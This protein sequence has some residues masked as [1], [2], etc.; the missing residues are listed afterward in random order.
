MANRVA[1]EFPRSG[2]SRT[3]C[4]GAA[5]A[6]L[7]RQLAA[8]TGQ[9]SSPTFERLLYDLTLPRNGA[10]VGAIDSWF[11]RS[12]DALRAVGCRVVG[13]RVAFKTPW[14]IDWVAKGNGYRGAVLQTE[15]FRLHRPEG[16]KGH[17]D[18][19]HAV[20]LGVDES[21]RKPTLVMIDP[22]PGRDPMAKPPATLELA[23]RAAKYG[24]VV[25]H[26]SGWS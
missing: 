8:K 14:L 15:R 22:W 10:D 5:A 13:R 21:G 7:L 23:H 1:V 3:A 12:R 6:F 26:W 11:A 2:M 17:R 18:T 24:G 4:A 9:P 19:S 20:A 25:V 16:V